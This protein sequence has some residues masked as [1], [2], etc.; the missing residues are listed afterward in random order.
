MT[1]YAT[2]ARRSYLI[3]NFDKILNSLNSLH[4]TIEAMGLFVNDQVYN[5]I[6]KIEPDIR[7]SPLY[8]QR[9]KKMFNDIC[10]EIRRYNNLIYTMNKK[11]SMVVADITQ[12]MEDELMPYIE[13]LSQIM[14]DIIRLRSLPSD[15]AGI[16]VLMLTISSLAA[17]SGRIVSAGYEIIREMG[18]G[19]GGNPFLFLDIGKIEYLATELSNEITGGEIQLEEDEARKVSDAMDIFLQEMSDEKIVD[20][21][22]EV[23]NETKEEENE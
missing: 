14:R 1:N 9:F 5:Y 20:K 13:N 16:A 17:V 21:I 10:K 3:N 2:E 23:I 19:Q 8:K 12:V 18:G 11:R 7:K 6:V 22:I 4:S 15:R